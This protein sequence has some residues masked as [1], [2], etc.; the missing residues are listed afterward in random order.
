ML[1]RGEFGF[2]SLSRDSQ[3]QGKSGPDVPAPREAR[4]SCMRERGNGADEP[5]SP[6][7]FANQIRPVR[8]KKKQDEVDNHHRGNHEEKHGHHNEFVFFN[9]LVHGRHVPRGSGR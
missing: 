4:Y 7:R 2:P 8:N 5:E 3:K 6:P 1:A 9:F